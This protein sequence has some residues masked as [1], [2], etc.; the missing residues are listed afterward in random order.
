MERTDH[1]LLVGE[2]ALAFAKAHGFKEE[3]LLTD[4]ARKAWLRWKEN[5][6]E[7]DDWF[8]PTDQ[9]YDRD[10][11]PTGT[12]HV[13][14]VDAEGNVGGVTTTSGLAFKI[15]GRVGDSPI[16]GAGLY[17]DNEVGAAGATGR[18]E[19]VIRTCGS[20][21]VVELMRQGKSPQQA[22]EMACQRIIDINRKN[23]KDIT[24][25]DK[26]VAVNI[27]GEVGCAAI[28]GSKKSAPVLSYT[29]ADGFHVYR[30]RYLIES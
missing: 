17:V 11:R 8:P 15:P 6:S 1:M 21:Y 10:Y 20:F 23:G 5:L 9:D 14:G 28:R 4:R 12:I 22:S 27:K 25:N 2:G 16:I 30:G 7:D 24:F 3:N 29:D 13:L 19:E 26:F 18:G